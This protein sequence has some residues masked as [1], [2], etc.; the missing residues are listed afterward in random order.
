MKNEKSMLSKAKSPEG[1]ENTTQTQNPI[2]QP[3]SPAP[4]APIPTNTN[5]ETTKPF[6]PRK[7]LILIG[8]LSLITII[9]LG[10]AL[11]TQLPQTNK[12]VEKQVKVLKTTLNI[13]E[14]VASSSAYTANVTLTTE[15]KK[16]TAV[17]IELTYNP[18]ALTNVDIKPGSFFP[19]PTILSKKIDAVKGRISYVLGIGLGQSSVNDNGIVAI[20]SF[21]T[22]PKN[23]ITTIA[24]LPI[25]KLTVVGEVP[26]VLTAAHGIQ[27][28]F[29]PTPT[30]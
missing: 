8:I 1:E 29:G 17:Q 10:L 11:Y 30:P 13:L 27:F 23:G 2:T 20:L 7:T 25:C 19:N 12:P 9:L 5:V 14:P 26:S 16:V 18:K 15:R 21:T 6:M 24:F 4:P 22:I 3:T 28:S